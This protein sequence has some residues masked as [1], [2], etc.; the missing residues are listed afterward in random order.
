LEDELSARPTYTPWKSNKSGV[1][2]QMID[3]IRAM[4]LGLA[5]TTFIIS[6]VAHAATTATYEWTDLRLSI[7]DAD[8]KTAINQR[9][10]TTGDSNWQNTL[11]LMSRKSSSSSLDF[12][13]SVPQPSLSSTTLS[14]NLGPAFGQ[15][16]LDT[17]T[18]NNVTIQLTSLAETPLFGANASQGYALGGALDSA[19]NYKYSIS[20]GDFLEPSLVRGGIWVQPGSTVT[21]SGTSTTSITLDAGDF[22]WASGLTQGSLT[23]AGYVGFGL[24][25]DG[26]DV[27]EP[28]LDLAD[29]VLLDGAEIL[30]LTTIPQ[31]KQTGLLVRDTRSN[32]VSG[33][34]TN[35]SAE[36]RWLQFHVE[37]V[38]F[39]DGRFGAGITPP[40]G[41]GG[42]LIPE[43]S[44][45]A[46]MGLGLVGM[47]LAA[48]RQRVRSC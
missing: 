48:R 10:E 45:Y 3:S 47:A 13:A 46:L 8:G 7:T 18:T 37:G 30:N 41:G 21:L 28:G 2:M 25:P 17:S 6:P 43:P 27:F 31:D 14:K 44:T 38:V 9:F 29:F 1:I 4:A 35:K 24:F 36:G 32:F 26:A 5:A 39:V 40:P 22:D 34:V 20:T 16:I 15:V 23:S 42:S 19:F 11:S 12:A 33:S